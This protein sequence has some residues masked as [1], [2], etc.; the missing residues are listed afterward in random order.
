MGVGVV[1]AV[2]LYTWNRRS[3]SRAAAELA[4]RNRSLNS[5]Y[6]HYDEEEDEYRR[7]GPGIIR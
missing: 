1:A 3:K 7:L 6:D 2:V 5:H 4:A